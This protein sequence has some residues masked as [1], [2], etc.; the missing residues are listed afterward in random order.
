LIL[1][2]ITLCTGELTARLSILEQQ[3]A[4]VSLELTNI[5]EYEVALL[6]WNLP[7][8]NRF[9]SDS[10]NVLLNGNRVPYI[11]ARV[12]FSF[13]TLDDYVRFA[14]NESKSFEVA[15]GNSYDFS[16]SGLYDV[17]FI[18][19]ILDYVTKDEFHTLPH[20]KGSWAPYSGII[21]NSLQITTTTSIL[22]K[23]IRVPYPCTSGE[24]TQINRAA[25]TQRTMIGYAVTAIGAGQS[26]SYSEWFGVYTA[27]RWGDVSYVINAVSRNSVVAYRCDNERGVYAYV[28]PTDT[29]HTIYLCQAFW[30]SADA[31]GFDT[32]AGTLI[33]ELSH[34]NNI[35]ATG[36]WAYGTPAARDLARS[37]PGRAIT[38]ADNYEYFCESQW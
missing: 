31:G 16:E 18:T 19:D 29:T 15:L 21:S 34:F 32:K 33:H 27:A 28:Y 12:K 9:Q 24:T 5:A 4:T 22:Q 25:S 30:G 35:G 20:L 3:S 6:R 17:V 8:D 2:I 23:I 11:G 10:F 7:L 37:N 36:D 26:G 14:P 1:L 13:P 38:N